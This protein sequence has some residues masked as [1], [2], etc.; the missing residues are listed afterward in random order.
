[1]KRGTE[2]DFC[3]LPH[4]FHCPYCLLFIYYFYWFITPFDYFNV[5]K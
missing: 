1:M 5:Y 4:H 3:P 2:L